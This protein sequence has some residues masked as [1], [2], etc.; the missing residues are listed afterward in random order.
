MDS[1]RSLGSRSFTGIVN[2]GWTCV[3]IVDGDWEYDIGRNCVGIVNEF[4]WAAFT[5]GVD[6]RRSTIAVEA[7]DE[8]CRIG[9][10]NGVNKMGSLSSMASTWGRARGDEVEEDFRSAKC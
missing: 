3:D 9:A 1:A 4:W 7:G 2:S 5:V 6:E 10:P 8:F